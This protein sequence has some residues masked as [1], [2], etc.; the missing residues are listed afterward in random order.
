MIKPSD[1]PINPDERPDNLPFNQ[2]M[3]VPPKEANDMKN[4]FAIVQAYR[5]RAIGYS[6]LMAGTAALL[7]FIA[8]K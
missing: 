8:T 4:V 2:Y 7:L 6:L 1:K 5:R 3:P